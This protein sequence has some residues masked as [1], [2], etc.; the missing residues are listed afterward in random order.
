MVLKLVSNTT[1][2]RFMIEHRTRVW[3][4]TY[5]ENVLKNC[6]FL[7]DDLKNFM[8]RRETQHTSTDMTS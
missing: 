3:Q 1:L 7:H 6:D 2:Y 8:H 5:L 4:M